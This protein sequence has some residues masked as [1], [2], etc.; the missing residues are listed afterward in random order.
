MAL[1]LR[2]GT[3]SEEDLSLYDDRILVN[4]EISGVSLWARV[5]AQSR[6]LFRVYLYGI[7]VSQPE[8]VDSFI[9][10][11]RAY[12]DSLDTQLTGLCVPIN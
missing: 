12:G 7:D 3:S 6:T 8:E 11:L 2:P 10:D 9:M 5:P 4:G 1:I